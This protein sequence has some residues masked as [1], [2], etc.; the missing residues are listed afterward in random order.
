MSHRLQKPALLLAALLQLL[1]VVR[2]LCTNP[3]A[4]STFAFIL[5]WG[6]GTGAVLGTVDAVSGATSVFS[7]PTTFSGAVGTP[8]NNNVTVSIGG[9]NSAAPNDYFILSS[10]SVSSTLL[11]SGQSTTATLP[12][13]LTFTASWVNGASTIGGTITGT[14]TT[15]GSYA[16][17]VTCVSPGNASLSQ[18]ITITIS[19]STTPTAPAITTQPV[20]STVVAGQTATFTAAASGTAPVGFYW[21]K[22]GSPLANGG[23]ISGANTTTLTLTGVSATD[24]G[25]YSVLASN[26]VGTATSASAALSVIVPPAISSQPAAQTAATGGSATFSVTATGTAPLNYRWLKN[27]AAIA[28]GT[29]YS[30]VSSSVLTVATVATADAGNYSV[31]I[32]NLAGSVT[33]SIAPLTV[34]SSPAIT[35][36]PASLSV[37]AGAGASFTVTAAG[38]APLVYQWLK[39]GAP[40]ADGGNVSGSATATLN[41]SAVSAGDAAGYSVIVSNSLGSATSPAATL[42]VLIPPAIVTPPASMTAIAGSNVSFTV[43]ASG[44]APLNFQWRKNGTAI[45]GATSA[46]LSLASVSAADAANYSVTVTNTAGSATS[47]NAT[48]TVL[49]PPA[50]TSQP[51]NATVVLGNPV[52]FTVTAG[53]TAPLSFQWLK[54]GVAIPN[55]NSNVLSFPTTTTN[56]AGNY[57][58]VVTN[59]VSSVASSGAALT[60]LV[61]AAIVTQPADATVTV[62]NGVS[63]TVTASGTAPLNFQWRKNGTA[64]SG[65]TSATLSLASVSAADAANYSVTVTNTAGSATSGNATLTVLGPPAITSQ[66]ANATVVLGNPVSFTVTAGGTAP[67][68]FQW[69]KNGVAIPNANSNVLSFPTTTTNDAGNYSVVVTNIVSSV[70]SSSAALTVLVPPAIVTQPADATVTAGNGVSFTVTASGTAPLNYQWRKN[71]VNISGAT[72][73]TLTLASVSAADAASYS[74]VVGNTAGSATSGNAVLTVQSPPAIVTQPASQFGALGNTTTLSATASGTA[75]LSWQWFKDGLALADSGNISGSATGTLTITALTTNDL[76]IY[77][78]VASNFLGSATSANASIAVNVAPV[79]TVPPAGQTVAVSNTVTFTAAA[80]GTGPLAWQWR[81]NGTNLANS[82]T[83]SGAATATLT[84]ANVTTNSSGNYSVVVTNIYGSATSP[85]A[86]LAVLLPPRVTTSPTN[87]LAKTGTNVTLAVT[88]T[89]TAP[90]NYQWFKDGSPLADGG[91]IAGSLSRVLTVSALTTADAGSYSVTVGNAVGSATSGSATL[92][93]LVPPVIT[94]QPASLS[95]TASNAATFSVAV[96]G[97]A[98]LRYQWRKAAVAIAGAT[99]STYTI[100][101]A[102]T[103]DAAVY[104]VV[105]T[106]LAGSVTSANATLT[107]NV[108]P[109]FTLQATNRFAKLG[110]NTIFR[111]AV[112]GTAPLGYQWFKDGNPLADGGN[113]SGSLSNVLTVA[114]LTTNDNGAYSLTA[115]NAAGSATSSNAVLTVLVPPVILAHPASQATAVSNSVKFTVTAAGAAPLRYQWRKGTTVIAGATNAYLAFASVKTSDA[116]VYSVVVTN[117]A[118]L[119]TSSNATLTVWVPPVF[120]LQATNRTATNGTTTVFRAAVTGTAPFSYQWFKNGNPLADGRNISGSLSNVLTVAN[121]TTND[122]GTYVLTASNAG[123]TAT[124]A[125]AVLTVKQPAPPNN[126]G[127]GESDNERSRKRNRSSST[128]GAPT[129]HLQITAVSLPVPP[130][131]QI[132]ANPDGSMT[133]QFSG[134][135]GTNYVLEATESLELPN[136]WSSI[137]TN[138]ATADGSCQMT[139]THAGEQPARFYRVRSAQ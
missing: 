118:G 123:G 83:V 80:A 33:S 30:G 110:T 111:A 117:L 60:V 86:A 115:N 14:P 91:N 122:A 138:R 129:T 37:S 2:T 59:I 119:V 139:D 31:I 68:S 127:G 78:V 124:S 41:L 44:T 66:P 11:L 76:G 39:N 62:G 8:F 19:G 26:S 35:T 45:S 128:T 88:A 16:T 12:P 105:V 28:N 120:T 1:P 3:A 92:T 103:T 6:I 9:G 107:V 112:S 77:F 42:T 137:G 74:V 98:P 51:A 65:A 126:G 135:P 29:K 36:P 49:G 23:N 57:S 94:A 136:D 131:L 79:I 101:S 133:L 96:T 43:T 21:S 87:L 100:A 25:N 10:G 102:K 116:A 130:T 108:A 50:I 52:S 13:G 73:A 82:A 81:K 84:L 63:F 114:N 7:T 64:I 121:V 104:S 67:L 38:S 27:G 132:A 5:R 17:T 106:N 109:V 113:I 134:Q 24:A 61:P 46:T 54:N 95:V 48:L 47:G 85:A 58:V 99:N 4:A 22:N 69:L 70:A 97:T 93:I 20:A 32:T 90:L 34:V 89:G 18:N 71:G 55:A 75:P 56:D 15:S 53:G 40:L 125:N 72:T